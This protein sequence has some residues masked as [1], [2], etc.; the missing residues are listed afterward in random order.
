MR[1]TESWLSPDLKVTVLSKNSDPRMG[2]FAMRLQN[3]DHTE[4]DPALFRVP[5][6]YQIVDENDD[7]IEMKV[8]RP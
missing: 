3:I 7:Q 1:V 4:P 6:D 8:T 2:E 5:A